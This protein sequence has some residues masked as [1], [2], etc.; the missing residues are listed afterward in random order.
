MANTVV[1]GVVMIIASIVGL[2]A[3]AFVSVALMDRYD[4][5]GACD[6]L[7]SGADLCLGTEWPVDWVVDHMMVQFRRYTFYDCSKGQEKGEKDFYHEGDIYLD[8]KRGIVRVRG[9]NVKLNRREFLLLSKRTTTGT[10]FFSRCISPIV[11]LQS[12]PRDAP[13][14]H[15]SD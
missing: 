2:L 7:Q 11:I 6:V 15:P 4:I 14:G 9:K 1:S 3:G 12:S 8:P 5:E 13:C 10:Y